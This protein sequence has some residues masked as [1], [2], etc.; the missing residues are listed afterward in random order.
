MAT[1][2]GP[3]HSDSASGS[4]FKQLTFQKSR[5]GHIV[6]G[7]NM[8]GSLQPFAPSA[9][10]LA[11]RA[12]TKAIMQEWAVLTTEQKSTWNAL[13][14][15][16]G[17]LACNVFLQENTKRLAADLEITPVWPAVAPLPPAIQFLGT[18]G[19]P[20]ALSVFTATFSGA[21]ELSVVGEDFFATSNL[22][23]LSVSAPSGITGIFFLDGF[24]QLTSFSV[25]STPLANTP[26]LGSLASLSYLQ[27][28]G[29]GL[30]SFP[31][32]TDCPLLSTINFVN[33]ALP[34]ID[35]LFNFLFSYSPSN[36]GGLIDLRGG[37]NAFYTSSSYAARISLLTPPHHWL[38]YANEEM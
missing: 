37:T 15:S 12:Q 31:S 11:L 13:A 10:Q 28:S 34:E 22:L 17:I 32:L 16:R 35:S 4:V 38:Y 2:S 1:V 24:T 33:N 6:R 18:E 19:S 36:S 21:G 26:V 27:L 8:P 5:R 14:E 23:T 25:L 29:C 3:L 7:Y 20:P 30:S 9:S